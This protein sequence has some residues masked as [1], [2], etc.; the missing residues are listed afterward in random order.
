MLVL[1]ADR[2]MAAR[3]A[4]NEY[5][6]EIMKDAGNKV[7]TSLLVRDRDHGSIASKLIEA[8]DPARLT[9]LE[10]IKTQMQLRRAK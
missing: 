3:A 2:D 4:E 7:V 10:F 9:V 1:C 8:N 5:L 6:V